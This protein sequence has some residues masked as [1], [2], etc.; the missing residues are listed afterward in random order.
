MEIKY[1][2][3]SHNNN[4]QCPLVK[5]SCQQPL[6][7]IKF[8]FQDVL[9]WEKQNVENVVAFTSCSCL[10]HCCTKDLSC[11]GLESL[12]FSVPPNPDMVLLRGMLA[13]LVLHRFKI[14]TQMSP[15]KTSRYVESKYCLRTGHQRNWFSSQRS[16]NLA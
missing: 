8:N 10:M 11:R 14:N 13:P 7:I 6:C 9:C 4:H 16:Q 3:P 12:I 15:I 1:L 5:M 2:T